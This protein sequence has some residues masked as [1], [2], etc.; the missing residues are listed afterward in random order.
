M[1]GH[2]SP[3]IANGST[4]SHQNGSVQPVQ[5]QYPQVYY[6]HDR[7]E[8]TRILIQGLM[9]LGYNGAAASLSRESGFELESPAV[10][11]FRNAILEGQWTEAE[12]ILLGSHPSD[13]GGGVNDHSYPVEGL[14]LAEGGDRNEMLF[15]MRQQKFLELL[16]QRDLGSALTVLRQELTPLHHD[17]NRLH[18]LSRSV[19]NQLRLASRR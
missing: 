14:V 10:A 7:E 1:N 4:P 15:W 18:F 6:G 8:V 13:G 12:G 17:I 3:S 2:S 19:E 16:E 5:A 11:A 9:D